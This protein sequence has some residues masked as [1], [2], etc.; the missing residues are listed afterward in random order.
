MQPAHSSSLHFSLA[1]ASS[2]QSFL[3]SLAASLSSL[4]WLSRAAYNSLTSVSSRSIVE[5]TSESLSDLGEE[6][7]CLDVACPPED[8]RAPSASPAMVQK[9]LRRPA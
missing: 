5:F 1:Q 9:L 7:A 2:S 3:R 4:F 8:A 6:S